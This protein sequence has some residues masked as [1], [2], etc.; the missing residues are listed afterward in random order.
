MSLPPNENPPAIRTERRPGVVRIV[1][2]R[3]GG[4]N[5]LTERMAVEVLQALREAEADPTVHVLTLTGSGSF[6]CG[7]GDV[8]DMASCP[9]DRRPAFIAS[10]A[11][12]AHELA[13]ALVTSRLLVIAGV[14]GSAAGAGLGLILNADW[15]LVAEEAS[16]L[17][18][19]SNL[20]LSP[21]TGVSYL[22]PRLVGHQRAVDLTLG[23]RRLSGNEA[24]EWGLANASAP[25][26]VFSAE[27]A[28]AED[29]FLQGAVQALAPT[30]QLLRAGTLEGYREHLRA[31]AESISMLSGHP[32]SVRRVDRFA[33][34]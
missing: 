11:N 19:Y 12:A 15:V 14:N 28:V 25:A 34:R 9:Q 20:G 18:A 7:G 31:E 13:W 10:L 3:S 6:F 30:K 23:R 2:D 21:D 26:Q 4:G 5:A 16:L 32:D 27:L 17:A 29:G 33:G 1:P 8:A 24:V 22:L